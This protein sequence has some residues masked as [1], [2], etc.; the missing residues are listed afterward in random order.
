MSKLVGSS[1]Y[2]AP[3]IRAACVLCL[4]VI[5]GTLATPE[6]CWGQRVNLSGGLALAQLHAPDLDASAR[7]GPVFGVDLFVPLGGMEVSLG[8]A[9]VTKGG[10]TSRVEC[11]TDS[12]CEVSSYD[13]TTV[14]TLKYVEIALRAWSP[15]WSLG[16]TTVRMGLGPSLGINSSCTVAPRAGREWNRS[17]EVGP[18]RV[19]PKSTD[20]SLASAIWLDYKARG[21][22]YYGLELAYTHGFSN[23]EEFWSPAPKRTRTLT[24]K[25]VLGIDFGR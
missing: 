9:S 2:T 22:E 24:L 21:G 20:W 14:I 6:P 8:V 19:Q 13:V 1:C 17:E 25:G 12:F 11:P 15:T 4:V 3:R 18:F 16:T 5:G 10:K 23:I 7:P